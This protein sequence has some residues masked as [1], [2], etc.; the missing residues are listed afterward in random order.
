MLLD[1][2]YIILLCDKT[3]EISEY[4]RL[5]EKEHSAQKILGDQITAPLTR[6]TM[7][8]ELVL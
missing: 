6:E 1:V 5:I 3:I 8:A 4:N 2:E 7:L